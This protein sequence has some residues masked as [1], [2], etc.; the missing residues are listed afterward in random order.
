MITKPELSM[1][2]IPLTPCYFG[3]AVAMAHRP[4]SPFVGNGKS[5]VGFPSV[6]IALMLN[7]STMGPSCILSIVVVSFGLLA[8]GSVVILRL[9]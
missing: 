2:G 4:T 8:G 3:Y 9:Q 5:E 1:T 6:V 7:P